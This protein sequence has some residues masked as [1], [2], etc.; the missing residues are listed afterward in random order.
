[1]SNLP[2][3]LAKNVELDLM[4]QNPGSS[5]GPQSLY[6]SIKLS[7]E[8]ETTGSDRSLV[9]TFWVGGSGWGGGLEENR[10]LQFETLLHWSLGS[11]FVI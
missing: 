6:F 4:P 5:Q 7:L 11:K 10:G 9:I 8:M 3:I 1:M 2:R